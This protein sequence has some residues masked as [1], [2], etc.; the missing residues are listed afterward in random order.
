MIALLKNLALA[1]AMVVMAVPIAICKL[2]R[3]LSQRDDWFIFFAQAISIVPG[4]PGRFLRKAYYGFTLDSCP[5]DCD[6][7]F[8]SWFTHPQSVIGHRVYI[9]HH[10]TLGRIVIGDGVMVGNHSCFLNG[11]AQHS[12]DAQGNLTAFNRG[13]LTPLTIGARTWIGEQ[14]VVMADIGAQCIIGAASVVS[15]P[16]R[17]ESVVA[18]NPARFVRR[19]V[20]GGDTPA[21][22]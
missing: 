2:E 5:F 11:G 8:L 17:A 6:I 22:D 19:V 16:V 1:V 15:S 10:V 20:I 9:G 7:G 3:K 18:G 14:A 21:A 4:F 13:D 12:F